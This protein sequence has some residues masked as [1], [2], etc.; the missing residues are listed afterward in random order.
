M[1]VSQKKQRSQRKQYLNYMTN[2]SFD[3][4]N[5]LTQANAV[6]VTEHA[7]RITELSCNIIYAILKSYHQN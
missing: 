5:L 7:S 3:N 6:P 4:T 1:K 2:F